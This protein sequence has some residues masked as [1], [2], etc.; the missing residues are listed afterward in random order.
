MIEISSQPIHKIWD[1]NNIFCC[2][3]RLV[4]GTVIDIPI[5]V[6]VYLLIGGG[7]YLYL[8]TIAPYIYTNITIWLPIISVFLFTACLIS[9]FA[10]SCSDPGIIPRRKYFELCPELL[11]PDVQ[12]DYYLNPGDHNDILDAENKEQL[13]EEIEKGLV[14]DKGELI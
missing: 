13:K 14:M 4:T 5:L 2:N 8:S 7:G 10:S 6:I 1:G 12:I 9:F 11:K 3:G